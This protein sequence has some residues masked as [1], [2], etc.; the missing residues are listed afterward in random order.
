MG[1]DLFMTAFEAKQSTFRASATVSRGSDPIKSWKRF[2]L[3]RTDNLA[4]RVTGI[5]TEW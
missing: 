1:T 4:A 2:P 5:I 3:R